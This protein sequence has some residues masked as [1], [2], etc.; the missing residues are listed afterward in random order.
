MSY[1]PDN[2]PGNEEELRQYLQQQNTQID[3]QRVGQLCE[4]KKETLKKEKKKKKVLRRKRLNEK[5]LTIFRYG[6]WRNH[7]SHFM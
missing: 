2:V 4:A 5:E 3:W 1:F 7:K 6:R